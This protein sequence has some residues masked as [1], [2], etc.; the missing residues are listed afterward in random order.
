MRLEHYDCPPII[1]PGGFFYALKKPEGTEVERFHVF[2]FDRGSG[3][4]TGRTA[5]KEAAFHVSEIALPPGKLRGVGDDV[6]AELEAVKDG[7]DPELTVVIAMMSVDLVHYI[8]KPYDMACMV[9]TGFC[10]AERVVIW[11]SLSDEE[12]DWWLPVL[13]HQTL[14]DLPSADAP[15]W[16]VSLKERWATALTEAA[17]GWETGPGWGTWNPDALVDHLKANAPPEF[18][19]DLFKMLP[20]DAAKF[21]KAR[22]AERIAA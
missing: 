20:I 5:H 11:N 6:I 21:Y 16:P 1:A 13:K 12:K 17:R 10:R 22:K 4:I 3:R 19:Q 7:C 9:K 8:T 18:R 2:E 14:P 15:S